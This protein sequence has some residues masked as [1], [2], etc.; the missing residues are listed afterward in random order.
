MD[1]ISVH[2]YTPKI[3][4]QSNQWTEVALFGQHQTNQDCSIRQ[5]YGVHFMDGKEILLNYYLEKGKALTGY[6]ACLMDTLK[7]LYG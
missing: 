1:E 5:D 3:K 7:D 2:H 6:Y 4:A